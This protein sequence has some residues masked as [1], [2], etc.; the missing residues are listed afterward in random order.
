MINKVNCRGSTCEILQEMYTSGVCRINTLSLLGSRVS[1]RLVAGYTLDR[2]ANN[3]TD[4]LTC[5]SL[6]TG[7]PTESQTG[8]L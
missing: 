4:N 2:S 7:T 8:R 5:M 6:D 3:L 1:W